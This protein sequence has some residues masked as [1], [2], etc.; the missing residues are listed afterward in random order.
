MQKASQQCVQWTGG[1]APRFLS[2]SVALSFYRFDG[3]S[4]PTHLPLTQAVGWLGMNN[5]VNFMQYPILIKPQRHKYLLGCVSCATMGSIGMLLSA[6]LIYKDVSLAYGGIIGLWLAFLIFGSYDAFTKF[7]RHTLIVTEDC[8][9]IPTRNGMRFLSPQFLD[10]ARTLA[11]MPK[12][13]LDNWQSYSFWLVNGEKYQIGKLL[14]T[15]ADLK[16][17]LEKLGCG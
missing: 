6:S 3:E 5:N 14:Y 4:Q 15:A 12:K 16:I 2:I 10:K 11:Y 1:Y 7:R 9:Q 17:V 13:N 8:V